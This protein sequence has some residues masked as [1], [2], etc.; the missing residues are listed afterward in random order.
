MSTTQEPPLTHGDA[1]A[2]VAA[3]NKAATDPAFSDVPPSDGAGSVEVVDTATEPGATWVAQVSMALEKK[4][5]LTLR[6]GM[7]F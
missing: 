2:L 6:R 5:K 4:P 7:S 1:G 3:A